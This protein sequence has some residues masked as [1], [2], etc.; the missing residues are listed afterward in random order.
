MEEHVESRFENGTQDVVDLME[1]VRD[2]WFK[3]LSPA[4]IRVLFDTK[5]RVVAKK[6]VLGRIMKAN[7]LIRRLTEHFAPGGC[8][9]VLFLDKLAYAN[10]DRDDKIRLIRHEL[11]HCV[12]NPFAKNVWAL[13]PHDIEDFEA[14]IAL[15]KASAGWAKRIAQITLAIYEQQK[16]DNRQPAAKP[17]ATVQKQVI[18]MRKRAQAQ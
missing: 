11:R 6:L 5:K 3:G 9:Y 4:R 14:E 13:I 12:Y 10:M 18:P 16:D 1:Q 2:E 17:E 8:D 7:D 15:N